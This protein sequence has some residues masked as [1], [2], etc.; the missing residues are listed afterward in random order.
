VIEALPTLNNAEQ[1]QAVLAE[2]A[3]GIMARQHRPPLVDF[4]GLL[5]RLPTTK[6]TKSPSIRA[7]VEVEESSSANLL[8]GLHP[9][10]RQ[11]VE[12]VPRRSIELDAAPR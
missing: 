2:K 9:I 6:T 4:R 3:V 1:A 11:S 10:L 7:V 8:G 5:K 12:C